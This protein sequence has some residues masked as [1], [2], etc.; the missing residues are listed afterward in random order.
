M[1]RNR[2]LLLVLGV[3]AV[4]SAW[5]PHL[6]QA[7]GHDG[8]YMGVG[9]TQLFMFTNER[10]R[11]AAPTGRVRFG[12]GYGAN[13]VIGYDFCG[14]RWGIQLPF[15]FARLKLNR[16]E[17]VNQF[18][19]SVEGVLHL[20]EWENGVDFHLLVGAGWSYISEGKIDDRSSAAGITA[21]F[22]PGVSYYFSRTEKISAA[23][24][25]ELPFRMIYYFGDNLT[26]GGT[27]VIAAPIRLN[28]QIGF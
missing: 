17:W 5:R 2:A 26:A 6:A 4:L 8:F 22:G 27:T 25:V 10:S 14:S 1:S 15:E 11:S 16:S 23:V 20:A 3:L 19:S 9:Y 13:A 21:S 28:L 7:C 18:G 24:S 12:P